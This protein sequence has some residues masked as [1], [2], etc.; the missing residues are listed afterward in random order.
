[1][2]WILLIIAGFFE[3]GFAACLGKAKETSGTTPPGG[4]L[5]FL[6]ALALACICCIAPRK[7]YPLEPPMQYGPALALWEPFLWEFLFLRSRQ[8]FG[9]CFL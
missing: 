6:F 1:M 4:L 7:L 2:N 8:I 5:V 3:V 9:G